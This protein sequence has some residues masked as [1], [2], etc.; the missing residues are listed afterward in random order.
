MLKKTI[1]SIRKII[2]SFSIN[3]ATTAKDPKPAAIANGKSAQHITQRNP[4][5]NAKF[6]NNLVLLLF[7]STNFSFC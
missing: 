4:L 2:A 3:I 6:L 5:T 7:D 1:A